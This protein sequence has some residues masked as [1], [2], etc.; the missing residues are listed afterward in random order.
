MEK[1][2]PG[3]LGQS[4]STRKDVDGNTAAGD[5]GEAEEAAEDDYD[6]DCLRRLQSS[7]SQDGWKQEL[8]K[9]LEYLDP[10]ATKETDT[11]EWWSVCTTCCRLEAH[12]LFTFN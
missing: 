3:R 12:P 2:W 6:R 10:D 11:V 8:A 1:Y 7:S 9:Y 4:S 5:A